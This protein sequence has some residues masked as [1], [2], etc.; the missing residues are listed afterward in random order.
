MSESIEARIKRLEQKAG[1]PEEEPIFILLEEV[2]PGKESPTPEQWE[3]A[4]RK[5]VEAN[6]SRSCYVIEWPP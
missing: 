5:A 3:E 1:I 4:K 6:P 2:S